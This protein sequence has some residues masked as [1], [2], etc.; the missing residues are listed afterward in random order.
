MTATTTEREADRLRRLIARLNAR[1]YYLRRLGMNTQ[2]LH[3]RARRLTERYLAVR[4]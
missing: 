3:G 4:E 1:H 2:H